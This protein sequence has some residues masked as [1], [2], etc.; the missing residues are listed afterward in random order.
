MMSSVSEDD[1]KLRGEILQR[2]LTQVNLW[3][4][5]KLAMETKLSNDDERFLQS[6]YELGK[7]VRAGQ[8]GAA[9]EMKLVDQ[10]TALNKN[11]PI[12]RLENMREKALRYAGNSVKL[13]AVVR[14]AAAAATTAQAFANVCDGKEGRAE[15]YVSRIPGVNL[16]VTPLWIG[17]KVHTEYQKLAAHYKQELVKWALD[18]LDRLKELCALPAAC[19][20][21]LQEAAADILER[22]KEA[23]GQ[24]ASGIAEELGSPLLTALEDAFEQVESMAGKA[25]STFITQLEAV[26]PQFDNPL[27]L[28]DDVDLF[29]PPD[30]DYGD[31]FE[32]L[33]CAG[34]AAVEALP[35]LVGAFSSAAGHL[36]RIQKHLKQANK[37]LKETVDELLYSAQLWQLVEKAQ[38]GSDDP[39][40]KVCKQLRQGLLQAITKANNMLEMIGS[41]RVMKVAMKNKVDEVNHELHRAQC[42]LYQ[43]A[44]LKGI[45]GP[46]AADGAGS[47]LP[48]GTNDGD[49]SSTMSNSSLRRVWDKFPTI[50][51]LP[52]QLLREIMSGLSTN[53]GDKM[54]VLKT[55]MRGRKQT[56]S[57]GAARD[58]KTV[59]MRFEDFTQIVLEAAAMRGNS[60]EA[61][62]SMHGNVVDAAFELLASPSL[63]RS[64]TTTHST[65]M[66]TIKIEDL[67]HAFIEDLKARAQQRMR[68]RGPEGTGAAADA[69]SRT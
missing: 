10:V 69:A 27:A 53:S 46:M 19:I 22:M 57:G 56:E 18:T 13:L 39:D 68:H 4:M 49:G 26:S 6:V 9:A 40:D 44:S 5:S 24:L 59:H 14:V 8:G 50:R 2:M 36:L 34:I 28:F 54:G 17:Q 55:A 11:P 29:K 45:V 42:K 20:E 62:K 16:I 60:A 32:T 65:T 52:A 35:D 3:Q 30:L 47:P 41:N 63:S 1:A 12:S 58:G 67:R 64:T 33:K 48:R 66:A 25:V 31:L 37:K 7:T 61:K 38:R 43:F 15:A 51:R 21:A 23:F